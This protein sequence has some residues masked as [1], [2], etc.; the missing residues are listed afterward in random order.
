MK[1]GKTGSVVSRPDDG[2][3]EEALQPLTKTVKMR[4]EEAVI[5]PVRFAPVSSS[6]TS[7]EKSNLNLLLDVPLISVELG[8]PG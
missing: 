1:K 3:E 8:V 2:A 6:E 7:Q 5:Q 4:E